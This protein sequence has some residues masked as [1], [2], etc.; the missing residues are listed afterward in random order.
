VKIATYET[1]EDAYLAHLAIVRHDQEFTNAPRGYPSREILGASYRLANPRE[2]VIRNRER[3]SNIVFNFA[4]A[5]WY[6]SGSNSLDLV[7]FYAPSMAKYSADSRTLR[8]TAYGARIFNFGGAGFDQWENV[9]RTLRDDPESK[10]AMIQIFAP[11]ELLFRDNIDV[12]C[13][14]GL[15]YV[16]RDEKLHAISFMRANDAYRG[17]VS[18]VFSFTFL[19]ELLAHQLGLELGSYFHVAGSYHLYESD[20]ASA[21]RVLAGHSRPVNEDPFPAMP[22]GDNWSTIYEVLAIEQAMR[23][24]RLT[25]RRDDVEGL[26]LAPYWSQVVALLS[27]YAQWQLCDVAD[28]ELIDYLCPLYAS[29]VENRWRNRYAA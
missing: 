22:V 5:L 4:E 17:T 2:R 21:D 25:V 7:S 1:F 8:G 19:Q 14:L 20:L 26:G 27:L 10:R 15:Q 12:A 18:D 29:L 9:I 11:E 24:G 16:I 28:R 13:T 23:G 3:K 6:L